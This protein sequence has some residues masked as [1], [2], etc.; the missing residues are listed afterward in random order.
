MKEKEILTWFEKNAQILK[1]FDVNKDGDYSFHEKNWAVKTAIRWADRVH[2]DPAA[3]C[4]Y[5]CENN[6]VHGPVVWAELKKRK[7]PA[8]YLF[9]KLKNS[10]YW[11]PYKIVSLIKR[12]GIE[13]PE[14]ARKKTLPGRA[15]RTTPTSILKKKRYYHRMTEEAIMQWFEENP[16]ALKSFDA[17]RDGTASFQEKRWAM[18]VATRWATEVKSDR[19]AVQWYY[20]HQ[21]EVFG[22]VK[23][24]YLEKMSL[25]S[26]FLFIKLRKSQYWLPSKIV[27]LITRRGINEQK[28]VRQG[29]PPRPRP[30]P[31]TKKRHSYRMTEQEIISWFEENASAL[32]NF[33]INKD[34]V[35]SFQEKRW[36]LKV[37]LKWT[38]RIH[39]SATE[40]CWIYYLD[41]DV[42]GPVTWSDLNK[43]TTPQPYF[44]IRLQKSR[45]W[46]PFQIIDLIVR[47]GPK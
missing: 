24:S 13:R 37:A 10:P 32:K 14:S 22:P 42:H 8:L 26:S 1:P 12:K 11:L 19:T 41:G 3:P 44:F 16:A 43:V 29:A 38:A 15:R 47:R 27:S 18:K 35:L 36:A 34:K 21:G 23:W 2:A 39:N 25:P 46:L 6:T 7:T 20:N 28:I 4:W 33:D 30:A 40:T 31:P 5:Y 17:D 45:Y 9:I